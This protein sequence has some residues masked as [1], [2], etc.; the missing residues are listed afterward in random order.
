MPNNQTKTVL[1]LAGLCA[2][3]SMAAVFAVV[4]GNTIF[5]GFFVVAGTNNDSS[6]HGDTPTDL[7]NLEMV[8]ADTA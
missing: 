3:S 1:E 2:P 8:M 4:H 7:A 6:D 5:G